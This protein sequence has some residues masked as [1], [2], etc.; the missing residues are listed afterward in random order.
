MYQS[1]Q[2]KYLKFCT[3][4]NILAIPTNEHTLCYYVSHL[5]SECKLKYQSVK[6]YLSAVR[7]LQITD[8]FT[9][10][11]RSDM[12]RLDYVMK[13]IKRVQGENGMNRPNPRLP[14]TPDILSK[15][16]GVWC[17][18]A[19]KYQE[20]MLW[21]AASIAFF[22]FL[23]SGELTVP[24][25]GGYDPS[26]H[27]SIQDIA[28]DSHISPSILRIRLKSSKTD[29]FRNG[30]DIYIGR[31]QNDTNLCPVRAVQHYLALRGTRSGPLF[32]WPDNKPLV[33]SRFV[34]LLRE[35][36]KRAGLDPEKY[37]GHSF[38]IGAASTAAMRGLED[39]TIKTLGR[40]N[41]GAY[42][43]YIKLPTSELARYSQIL[44]AGY[45]TQ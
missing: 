44:G 4:N 42:T 15:L 7:H 25:E 9:D 38:R 5:A 33:K 13:G 3:D 28:V 27:L 37:A 2:G 14:I 32:I 39:S 43:R 29:P 24:D 8:G 1:A 11:F 10:P 22:G 17:P 23:R 26:T 6:C 35:A 12:P 31:I 41:S 30:V 40:W 34:S 36:L 20:T 18:S 21:A 16:K 45:Q 19:T